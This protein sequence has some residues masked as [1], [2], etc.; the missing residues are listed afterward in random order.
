MDY[1]IV[2]EVTTTLRPLW[3]HAAALTARAHQGQLRK[4]GKTPYAS[5]PM[6]VA[7]TVACLFG[8]TDEATIA[9]ALL[10]DV[11]EDCQH[12]YDD[13]E[14]VFGREIA[15]IVAA[16]TK[17]M[18]LPEEVR[19]PEYDERLASGPWQARLI[20]LADVYD[21]YCDAATE[22]RRLKV[23]EKVDRALALADGDRRLARAAAI[24][25]QLVYGE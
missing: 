13:I 12:D 23:R 6:R 14:E 20:K 17:D 4:D 11:I 21:N 7:M 5:H 24:V 2:M 10:H 19:E 8:V 1:D 22:E 16:L 15:D 3:Q 9:A 25:R 18:R